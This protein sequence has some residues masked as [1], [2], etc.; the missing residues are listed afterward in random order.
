MIKLKSEGQD[1]SEDFTIE[2]RTPLNIPQLALKSF[3][4]NVSWDNLSEKFNNN[5]FSIFPDKRLRQITIPNGLYTVEGLNRYMRK[6]FGKKPLIKFGIIEER[7]R[8]SIKL[9]PGVKLN[10]SEGNFHKLIGFENKE[11]KNKD[12]ENELELEGKYKANITRDIDEIY[13]HCNVVDGQMINQENSEVIYSFTNQNRPR[14]LISKE[15]D[16]LVFYNV[17]HNPIHRIRM[18]ITNQKGELIDL[19]KGYVEYNFIPISSLSK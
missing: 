16:T 14:T 8:I 12:S 1:K 10:L 11:F 13:I 9:S 3:S 2:Y 17:K 15:F 5:K 7:E 4:I 19:N 18:R 6:L